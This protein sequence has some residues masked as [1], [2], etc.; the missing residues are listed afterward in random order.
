MAKQPGN[1]CYARR[2]LFLAWITRCI[3]HETLPTGAFSRDKKLCK[4][5]IAALILTYGGLEHADNG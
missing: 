3:M 4:V 2:I 5:E 1:P